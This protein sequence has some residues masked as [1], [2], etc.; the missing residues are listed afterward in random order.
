M[1][2]NDQGGSGDGYYSLNVQVRHPDAGG[3]GSDGMVVQGA[4]ICRQRDV[5]LS[6]AKFPLS[7]GNGQFYAEPRRIR[8]E[9]RRIVEYRFLTILKRRP[10]R[11]AVATK[12]PPKMVGALPSGRSREHAIAAA[13]GDADHAHSGA[14]RRRPAEAGS[15]AELHL[16]VHPQLMGLAGQRVAFPSRAIRWAM[17]RP[18][19]CVSAER[20]MVASNCG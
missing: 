9:G 4:G 7:S 18:L 16:A 8:A 14:T 15:T 11:C 2:I 3:G 17:R 5:G 12:A 13:R 19:V 6:H 10:M 1:R 20:I